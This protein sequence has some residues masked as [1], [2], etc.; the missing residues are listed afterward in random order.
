VTDV[1]TNWQFLKKTLFYISFIFQT[2]LIKV[3]RSD[4]KIFTKADIDRAFDGLDFG[5]FF[6]QIC[7]IHAV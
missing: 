1:L 4:A 2:F 5:V 7:P 6:G 3:L